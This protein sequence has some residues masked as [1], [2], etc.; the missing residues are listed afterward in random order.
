MTRAHSQP[1]SFLSCL[2]STPCV[3]T[4]LV[5]KERDIF[6]YIAPPLEYK[7]QVKAMTRNVVFDQNKTRKWGV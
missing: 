3:D 4:T 2:C 1:S 7:G 6:G 5:E